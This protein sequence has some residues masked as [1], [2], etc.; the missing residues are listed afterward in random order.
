[1]TVQM[2]AAAREGA[3]RQRHGRRS[4]LGLLVPALLAFAILIGFGIWQIQ[5]KAWKEGLIAALDARLSV[6]PRR[7]IGRERTDDGIIREALT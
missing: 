2:K 6:F 1:M 3:P 5:R 7:F 4:W